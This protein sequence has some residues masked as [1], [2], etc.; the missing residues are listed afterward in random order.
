MLYILAGREYKV[1]TFTLPTRGDEV[2]MLAMDPARLFNYRDSYLFFQR[3]PYLRRVRLTEEER[4]LLVDQRKLVHWFRNRDV[5]VVSARSCFKCFGHRIIKNGRRIVDDYFETR[6]REEGDSH[7]S[8]DGENIPRRALI[9]RNSHGSGY[10]AS[11]PVNAETWLHHAALAVRGFNAQLHQRRAEKSVFYDIHTNVHQIASATQPTSCRY[12]C[13]DSSKDE[14]SVGEVQFEK[15]S[16]G[17]NFRGIGRDILD[18]TYD[19]E[20]VLNSL[21]DDKSREMASK[22]IKSSE[23]P[24]KRVDEIKEDD[25][26]PIAL[27]EGQYQ[28]TFPM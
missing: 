5:A 21:P 3:N 17:S 10:N 23:L 26:Y 25:R 14:F 9:S 1:P 4:N 27:M 15:N 18:G 20:D 8:E 24:I 22:M 13:V 19:V 12:E 2:F 7:D 6:A 11:T 16:A 28:A